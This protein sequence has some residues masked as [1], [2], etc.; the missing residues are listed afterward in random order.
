MAFINMMEKLVE[1]R[2]D[3]RIKVT[4]A[5]NCEQCREDIKC[6]ALN[7]LPPKYVSTP[8]G[9]LFSKIDQQMIRQNVLDI[10]V[11]VI[12]AMEFVNKNPRH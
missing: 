9:E 11:A 1:I 10:D 6:I 5:C 12:N 8:K 2:L 4:A 7:N 3:E